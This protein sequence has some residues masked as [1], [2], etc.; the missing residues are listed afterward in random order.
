MI[1]R[2]AWPYA[3]FGGL[4]VKLTDVKFSAPKAGVDNEQLE[5]W[6]A[7]KGWIIAGRKLQDYPSGADIT[8]SLRAETVIKEVVNAVCPAGSDRGLDFG[9]QIICQQTKHRQFVRAD[10]P[11]SVNIKLRLTLLGGVVQIT[12]VF[13]TK[14]A[15]TT[16][17]GV[18]L[19]CG[20]IVA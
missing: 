3:F 14:D 9:Y 13:I 15:T 11:G 6:Q 1:E 19:P 2:T 10:T 5:F 16:S 17:D 12:P 4:E 7:Y 20:G 18:E 8:I